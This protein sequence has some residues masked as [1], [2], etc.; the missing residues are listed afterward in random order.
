MCGLTAIINL[1]ENHDF[2]LKDIVKMNN[3]LRHRGPDDEGYAFFQKNKGI[4]MKDTPSSVKK[5]FA[6]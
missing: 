6:I 4:Y 5:D 2:Q 3:T 1:N